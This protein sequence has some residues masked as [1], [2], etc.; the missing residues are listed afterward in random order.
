MLQEVQG[1]KEMNV[2][3]IVIAGLMGGCFGFA[4]IQFGLKGDWRM[5]ALTIGLFIAIQYLILWIIETS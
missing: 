5:V 2:I 4:G 1:G 3:R